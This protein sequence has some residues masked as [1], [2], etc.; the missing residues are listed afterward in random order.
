MGD[1]KSP[2]SPESNVRSYRQP[3]GHPPRPHRG[4]VSGSGK[5][6]LIAP[7]LVEKG[8]QCTITSRQTRGKSP[9]MMNRIPDWTATWDTHRSRG[10]AVV[11]VIW[12]TCCSSIVWCRD[13][14]NLENTGDV[15]VPRTLASQF[16]RFP[17]AYSD[18]SIRASKTRSLGQAS[19]LSSRNVLSNTMRTK[20][21]GEYE[22][23]HRRVDSRQ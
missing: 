4:T 2:E 14:M 19:R 18:V 6:N 16:M 1:W 20:T 13:K 17:K 10:P 7:T 15:T 3:Q 8:K 9:L 12:K 5:S 21:H 23:R 11:G 22:N